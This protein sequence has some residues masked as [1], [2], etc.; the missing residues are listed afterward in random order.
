MP[1]PSLVP[2]TL[3]HVY[4]RGVNRETLFRTDTQYRHFW[5]LLDHHVAPCADVLAFTL[6]PNHFHLLLVAHAEGPRS[7]SQALSNACNAYAKSVNLRSGRVGPLFCRPFQRKAI[8][9]PAYAAA[10]MS[11]VL[12]NAVHHGLVA[13]A[14]AWPWSSGL[15]RA[16]QVPYGVAF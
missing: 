7:T 15:L 6:L 2:G 5:K 4:N 1:T 13:H 3:Y 14:A 9:D 16:E 11:Y 8:S 12:H 10:A